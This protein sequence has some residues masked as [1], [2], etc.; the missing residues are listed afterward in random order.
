MLVPSIPIRIEEVSIEESFGNHIVEIEVREDGDYEYSLEGKNYQDE[1]RFND[2]ENGFYAIVVRDKNGCGI[3]EK[4]I[5]VIGFPKRLTPNGDGTNDRWQ[6]TG[7]NT[8]FKNQAIH[9]YDRYGKQV[10]QIYPNATGWEGSM[11]GQPLPSSDYL[12]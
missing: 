7:A 8:H 5:S 3:P 9:S 6:I 10:K 4:E 1:N 11:N 12:V 2:V